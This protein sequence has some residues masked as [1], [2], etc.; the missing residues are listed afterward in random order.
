MTLIGLIALLVVFKI[1]MFVG[2]EKANFS[3]RFGQNYERNFIEPRRGLFEDFDDRHFM[4]AH[5]VMGEI[6][7][8]DGSILVVNDRDN[9]EKRVLTGNDT[10]IMHFRNKIGIS[11]LKAGELVAIIG[12]P[13]NSGSIEARLIR[14]LRDDQSSFLPFSS[15][16]TR[17]STPF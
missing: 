11:D 13:D 4:E 5:G 12:T 7:K 3:Y 17:E 10:V 2:Y 14:V 1:G 8:I 16:P 15:M 6:L 9:I